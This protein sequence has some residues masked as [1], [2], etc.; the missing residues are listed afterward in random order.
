[1]KF[2]LKDMYKFLISHTFPGLLVLIEILLCYQ[3]FVDNNFWTYLQQKWPAETGTIIIIL[4]LSYA[5]STLLGLIVDSVHHFIHDLYEKIAKIILPD[6][7]NQ[8]DKN[9]YDAIKDTLSLEV[10]NSYIDDDLYYYYEAYSNICVAMVPGLFL[11]WHWLSS[12]PNLKSQHFW[13]AMSIYTIILI[14]TFVEAIWT[15]S[16]YK[17]ERIQFTESFSARKPSKL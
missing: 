4:I 9:E 16:T 17:K 13:I 1:M 7:V 6:N 11:F 14:I 3:W 8:D 2:E 5:F 12:V 15:F 10:Y